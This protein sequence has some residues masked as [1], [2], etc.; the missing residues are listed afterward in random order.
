MRG[1]AG[2]QLSNGQIITLAV[3]RAAVALFDEAGGMTA[4]RAKSERLTGYLEFLIKQLG[5]PQERLEIITPSDPAQ[6]A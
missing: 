4:L 5:L 3:Y 6:P 1:A 2:W